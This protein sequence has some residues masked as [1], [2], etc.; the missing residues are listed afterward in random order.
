MLKNFA[1]ICAAA[2]A[3]FVLSASEAH[4]GIN[5]FGGQWVNQSSDTDD[6]TRVSVQRTRTGLR[7][8]VFGR[9]HPSDCD[10]GAVNATAFAS[11]A[12]GDLER[13]ADVLMATYTQGFARKTVL[14]R[15]NG[16]NIAY[17]VFT[18]LTD[19][20][21]RANYR[22]SGRLVHDGVVGP[23]GGRRT[24]WWPWPRRRRRRDQ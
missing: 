24:W 21:G 11:R 5:D 10:W 6:V 19:R 14:L 4:A 13:D 8:N 3:L 17:E 7:V 20:S 22:T 23:G 1:A 9:C 18:E 16:A 15:L 2:S 12:G